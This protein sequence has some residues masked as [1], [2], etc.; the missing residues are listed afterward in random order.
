MFIGRTNELK[1]LNNAY[2]SKQAE[3]VVLYGRRRV[4]KTKLLNEFCKDKACIFYTC[5]EYTDQKQLQSFTEKVRSYGIA[6]LELVDCFSDW[7]KAFSAVLHVETT[8]KKLLV[9][10]EFPYAC[11]ANE[12]IPSVLQVLWDEKLRHENVMI[13]LCGSAM[14]FI[15]KELLAEKNPLYGRATGIYKVKP[16]PYADALKFFPEFSDEDKLLAYAILGGIPH[17][18]KQ[19]DDETSLSD[20]VKNKV[21]NKGC[22]LYNEVEFLLKQELRETAIYN[23][24]IEAIALGNNSFADILG[25]TQLEKSKLS[26]YL[27]NLVEISIVEKEYPALSSGKEKSGALKGNYILTDNFFRFWYAFAYR[28][29]T[30]LENDDA[31]GVWEDSVKNNL[32]A[33]ASQPFEKLCL[34]YLYILNR[35]RKLPFRIHNASRYW[36]KTVQITDGKKRCVNIEIDI[37]APDAGRKNFIFGEC[38]FTNEQ[39]DMQQLRKLQSK[40]FVE[41]KVYYYLFSLSGFTDAVK[42]Y[43]ASHEEVVLVTA[44]D[45]VSVS[46]TV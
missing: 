36:G 37:L 15:E 22:P 35:N 11:R 24:I 8:G 6:A 34:E 28:N 3:L 41:G 17:Y 44:N 40:V 25:K 32:H 18:L 43:A 2:A 42:E 39:F 31:D 33:F 23:T 10:D 5:R 1:F 27:K 30:D 45:L 26:V 46:R 29:L 38:K 7:E 14:S 21:L 20:N 4:G 12:S 13:V 9:I 19:F 16:L